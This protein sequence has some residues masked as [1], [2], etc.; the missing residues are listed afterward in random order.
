MIDPRVGRYERA[1]T[2]LALMGDLQL[3]ALVDTAAEAG[4]G[5]GGRK[6]TLGVDGV[7]VFV[8]QVPL[9]DLELAYR[10]STA[11]LFGLPMFY[12]YGVGSAGF[13]A[14]RE[15]A[16]HVMSTNWVLA[17]RHPGFP[18]LYHW[19]VLPGTV[20]PEELDDVEERVAYWD[21]SDAVR[22]RLTALK[23]STMRLVLFLEHIP[24]TVSDWLVER[25]PVD[26]DHAVTMIDQQLRDGV[27]FMNANGL[28]HFDAHFRNLLT[29]GHRV[30][31]ADFGLALHERFELTP[32]EAIFLRSHGNYDSRYTSGHFA[33]WLTHELGTGGPEA[34][35]RIIDRDGGT[36]AVMTRFFEA[37][38]N[39]SKQTPYPFASD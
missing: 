5:I 37:L 10:H 6:V 1:A 8:K 11:N 16:M 9:A 17:G 20:V 25:L 18:L 33:T 26:G 13:G 30:Y 12:Q 19:R 22:Q 23:A 24:F 27:A 7:T 38:V 29:D 2:A 3:A 36:A 39:E 35:R 4:S 32:A 15:L 21:G 31:F 14:W 34:A 28:L